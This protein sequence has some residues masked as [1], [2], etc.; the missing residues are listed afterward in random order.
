MPAG[1]TASFW[2]LMQSS[3]EVSLRHWLQE[4]ISAEP[5]TQDDDSMNND[6]MSASLYKANKSSVVF[7]A[8]NIL[9]NFI[10]MLI[11]SLS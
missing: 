3:I 6:I 5:P 7:K 10:G 9:N 8:K 11:V 4:K 2:F 1:Q